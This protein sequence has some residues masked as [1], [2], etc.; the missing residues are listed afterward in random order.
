[1]NQLEE[2]KMEVK[3]DENKYEEMESAE[4][5]GNTQDYLTGLGVGLGMVAAIVAIT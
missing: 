2:K 1:M 4:E 3:V 5:L